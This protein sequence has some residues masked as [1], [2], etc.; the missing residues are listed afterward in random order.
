MKPTF[1]S[2]AMVGAVVTSLVVPPADATRSPEIGPP[3][4]LA[5]TVALR[6]G[7]IEAALS[8]AGRRVSSAEAKGSAVL[9]VN[10]RELG[11]AL[12]PAGSNLLVGLAPYHTGDEVAA[13]VTVSL[14]GQTVRAR[15]GRF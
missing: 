6:P 10:G 8:E 13:E 15:V 3:A 12:L 7:R 9:V 11:V 4:G 1:C 5:V 14:G 2:L